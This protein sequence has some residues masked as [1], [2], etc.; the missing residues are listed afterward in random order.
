MIT[1]GDLIKGAMQHLAADGL[2]MQPMAQD[3]QAA[4]QHLDDFAASY[5]AI[6]QDVGYLQPLEYGTSTESDDSGVDVSL[7]GPVK[8]MLAA[9]IAN[10]F[11]KELNPSKTVWAEGMMMKQL[12]SV[13]GCKYPVT[14]P[15]GSGNYDSMSD[16]Q[17]YRGGLPF[18]N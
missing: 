3:N 18:E 5:A 13:D 2:L 12:V 10:M 15:V 8:V 7:V 6:G 1:K 17:Y 14:L 9:Y 4:L 16:Q 11:G